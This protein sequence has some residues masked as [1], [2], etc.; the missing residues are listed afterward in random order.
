MSW[1]KRSPFASQDAAA[2]HMVDLLA[3]E[4]Q[5]RGMPLTEGERSI[6]AG[7][8]PVSDDLAAKARRLITEILERE[9]ASNADP[10]GFG[11]AME[12]ASDGAWS[13]IV[14]LTYTAVDNRCPPPRLHGWSKAKDVFAL[15]GCGLLVV[16]VM[17][18]IVTA[19]VFI[20]HL[21]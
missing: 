4:G 19:M 11:G 2:R 15:I 1:L 5:T 14:E 7:E 8:G 9:G 13:N 21:K 17:S 6:L 10:R 18:A 20:F 16:L 3:A 12:W